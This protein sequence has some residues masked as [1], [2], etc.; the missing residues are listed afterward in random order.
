VAYTRRLRRSRLVLQYNPRILMVNDQV[1]LAAANQDSAIDLL[2]AP[3]PH[4]TIGL[5]DGF[6][7]FGRV[8]TFNDKTLNSN[9]LSG[10]VSNPF[11]NIQQ[12]TLL[13]SFAVPINYNMSARSSLLISPLFNY[14]RTEENK[15]AVSAS[16]Q[17]TTTRWTSKQALKATRFFI[18]L[19]PRFRAA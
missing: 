7:Y 3:A 5:S 16:G 19:E 13:N 15:D 14:V 12:R 6:N 17:P 4:L 11:L 18:H 9:N 2:F 10:A 8:Q 1:T